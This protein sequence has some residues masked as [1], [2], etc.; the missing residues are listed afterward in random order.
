VSDPVLS[1]LLEALAGATGA[2]IAWVADTRAEPWTV[3][4]WVGGD[5]PPPATPW[6]PGGVVAFVV[7]SDQPAA[8][9]P[10]PG[11]ELTADVEAVLGRRPSAVLVV[12]CAA[13]AGT[14]GAVGLADK[15][16]GG[17]FSFDDIELA[18]LLGPV[19][20]AAVV[21]ARRDGAPSP[22]ALADGLRDLAAANPARYRRVAAAVAALL[23][24]P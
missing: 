2:R 14:V 21:G 18:A 5:P 12:P 23:D 6:P 9:V 17:P 10:R 16:G 11:V 13:D 4:E 3:V 1:S 22:A 8:L 7:E 19:A 24:G 20:A 15:D